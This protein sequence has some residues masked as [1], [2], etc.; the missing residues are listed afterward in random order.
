MEEIMSWETEE[1]AAAEH[2]CRR[3]DRTPWQGQGRDPDIVKLYLQEIGGCPLLTADEE[4]ALGQRIQAGDEEAVRIFQQANLRLVVAVAKRYVGRGVAFLDLI[5]EGNLGLMIAV[6]KFD[7]R[8]GNKFSTYATWWIR[9]MIQRAIPQQGRAIRLP[10]HMAEALARVNRAKEE[11]RRGLDRDPLPEEIAWHTGM[12]LEKVLQVQRAARMEAVS[13][14]RPVHEDDDAELG[15]FLEGDGADDPEEKVLKA[16]LREQIGIALET[17][18][19][20]EALV[21]RRRYGLDGQAPRTLEQ[22]G[23][24]LCLTRERVRQIEAKAERKLR[25]WMQRKGLKEYLK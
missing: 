8:L 20:R 4:R 3:A 10:V 7:W 23:A 22:V 16:S 13:L 21:I 17:L 2:L 19:P 9:Q 14:Q 24:E 18:T 6:R 15:D 1:L 25:L 11:L 12:P 5:Q